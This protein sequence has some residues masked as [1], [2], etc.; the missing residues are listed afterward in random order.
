MPSFMTTKFGMPLHAEALGQLR[1]RLRV[2]LQH[3]RLARHV[4]RRLCDLGRGHAA[5]SAPGRP[6]VDQH[7]HR[8]LPVISSKSAASASM[9]LAHRRQLGLARAAAARCPPGARRECGSSFRRTGRP[10]SWLLRSRSRGPLDRAQRYQN[11]GLKLNTQFQPFCGR[12]SGLDVVDLDDREAEEV[13]ARP[14][15]TLLTMLARAVAAQELRLVVWPSRPRPSREDD[16]A[17]SARDRRGC[18]AA[19][20]ARSSG[21]RSSAFADQRCGCPAAG[22]T[23]GTRVASLPH[24]LAL[25]ESTS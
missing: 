19:E 12:S 10:G 8:R 11:P 15:P 20:E 18:G 4:R 7:R 16:R 22:R 17:R 9:R 1:V 13:D 3:H 5:G 23:P 6:E 25:N 24:S 14:A 2:D 21:K